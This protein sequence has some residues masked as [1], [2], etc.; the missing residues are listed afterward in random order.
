M[1][2][3]WDWSFWV[4]IHLNVKNMRIK[5]VCN[6]NVPHFSNERL[7]IEFPYCF[8]IKWL[9]IIFVFSLSSEAFWLLPSGFDFYVHHRLLLRENR[10]EIWAEFYSFG[11]ERM[12]NMTDWKAGKLL[13][14]WVQIAVAVLGCSSKAIPLHRKNKFRRVAASIEIILL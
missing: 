3:E 11:I 10:Q 14:N 7:Q 5:F 12:R 1:R 4:I 2:T 6:T 13:Q 8:K 9:N